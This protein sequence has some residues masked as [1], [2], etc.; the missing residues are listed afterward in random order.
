MPASPPSVAPR[1]LEGLRVIVGVCA[2]IAAYKAAH[3][4]RGLTE[5]GA[6]VRVV[7]TKAS[8]EFVGIST[9][10]ALS[11]NSVR[12]SVFEDVDS[13]AHVR[14]GQEADA[15][16]VVPATADFMARA[17]MGRADDLLT[18]T[19]LVTRAPVILA[20]A[21]H[22]EMWEHPATR[23]NVDV[24]RSR[25]VRVIEPASGRLTGTDTG[26]G[27]LPEPEVIVQY[28]E[29]ILAAGSRTSDLEGTHVVIT[30][31]GTREALDPVRVLTNHSSGKQGAA[32]ARAAYVRGASVSLVL[33]GSHIEPPAGV[34]VV[35]VE[36]AKELAAAVRE[37]E[38]SAD[39]LIMAAAVSDFTPEPSRSKIKKKAGE[40]G[41][42]LH[43]V[44][45]EDILRGL[46]ERRQ[47]GER[48]FVICGFA[49]ETGDEHSS[50]LAHATRK[51]RA[52]GADLLAF[53]DVSE[54]AFG[55]DTNALTFLD[56]A[57][58]IRGAA[59]GTKDEVSHA[60][61]DHVAS[62]LKRERS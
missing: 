30:A 54:N 16:V 7:P 31:G 10:E 2:G 56:A 5:R 61:L 49:A 29:S 11:H 27:R 24:L 60:M 34:D 45:T 55:A 9:W 19:L 51:A 57:G 44:E 48:P 6:D 33:A 25:G 41:L 37:R 43:L 35:R 18:A 38:S 52:K 21:M 13:V 17:R 36:S 32:L 3:V 4:V 53:N 14:L 22:T 26:V 39:V 47:A 46:V 12:T 20:P 28:V 23:E 8:L 58:E 59:R 50:A 1:P 62:L 40:S 42:T 15:V